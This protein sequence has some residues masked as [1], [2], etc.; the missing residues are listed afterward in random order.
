MN[1]NQTTNE[2]IKQSKNAH[3]DKYNYI[4]N[5]QD[6]VNCMFNLTFSAN[7]ILTLS[8]VN[9]SDSTVL[10]TYI[11]NVSAGSQTIVV[12]FNPPPSLSYSVNFHIQASI[13]NP[14]NTITI[15]N[16]SFYS[17]QYLQLVPPS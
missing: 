3:G 12:L 4:P 8:M 1:R 10:S 2:F 9:T 13:T 16:N 7:D 17:V 15:D 6:Y 11:F 5:L 14:S